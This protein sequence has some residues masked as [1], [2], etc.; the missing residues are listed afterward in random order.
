MVDN[1]ID[2]NRCLTDLAVTDNQLALSASDGHHGVD[3]LDTGLQR[4]VHG[5]TE[6]HTGSFPVEGQREGLTGNGAGTV[7]RVTQGI[8]NTT[9]QAIAY[10]NRGN[11]AGATHGHVLFYGIAVGTHQ[12]D[13][14]VALFEVHGHTA[15]TVF[16]LDELTRTDVVET[17]NVGNT[18]ADVKH[19]TDFFERDLRVDLFELLFQYI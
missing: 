14:D 2:G 19:G 15:H 5:L 13:T 10:G 1:G 16:K 11:L 8:D 3:S 9:Y 17:E 12:D 6:N 7:D 4:L 18:V